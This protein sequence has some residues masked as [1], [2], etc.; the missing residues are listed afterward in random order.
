MSL[1]QRKPV[2]WFWGAIVCAL[3]LLSACSSDDDVF[4]GNS[5][6][7]GSPELANVL[8]L[9]DGRAAPTAHIM[10]VP[11][12]FNPVAGDTLP[13][14]FW[15]VTNNEGEYRFDSLPEGEFSLE[16]YHSFTKKRLLVRG[17]TASDMGSRRDTVLDTGSVTLLLP[18]MLLDE[19]VTV[20]VVGS[21]ISREVWLIDGRIVMGDLPA[22]TLDLVVEMDGE[23]PIYFD[24]VVVEPERDTKAGESLSFSFVAP[25]DLPEGVDSLAVLTDIPMVLRLDTL[26]PGY[27]SFSNLAGR[28]EATRISADGSRSKQLP[29][30]MP[31][32]DRANRGGVIWM[33]L[34]SLN[35]GDS[36][37]ITM[38]TAKD[39]MYAKD[40]F[41]TSRRYTGVFHM[42][43]VTDLS[44]ASEQSF[45]EGSAKDVI[46]ENRG[47]VGT[48]LVLTNKNA[49]VTYY[50]T[51]ASDSSKAS[52]Y[53]RKF[54]DD[55]A[56]SVWLSIDG[57]STATIFSKGDR[58]YDL[59]YD[60]D[61]GLVFSIY[62]EASTDASLDSAD[63][64]GYRL[65]FAS[66][67]VQ[68]SRNDFR[69]IAFERR[70]ENA[71][72]FIDKKK[73]SIKGVREPWDGE[74]YEGA[75]F[76][77][78]GFHGNIDELFFSGSIRGDAWNI[79]TYLNQSMNWPAL[80]PR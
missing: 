74:R 1:G 17:L 37:E 59:K 3:A 80:Q 56:F 38:N 46:L 12:D 67:E 71:T 60:P 77:I 13:D 8:V 62:H 78:G 55:I 42:D 54:E 64:A 75:N 61:S 4:A 57:D 41:P 24:S 23:A 70:G 73:I 47:A 19:Q 49:Y 18:D 51:A 25:I 58:Q 48:S 68:F 50:G 22:G 44:D 35:V 6:E 52:D 29:I 34:D 79:T 53:N 15:T 26:T 27:E 40:V 21:T 30:A 72:L 45:G 9:D 66:G 11:S 76:Q 43:P 63:A 16:A 32:F 36:I 65:Y 33:R 2:L 14:A 69:Y 10:C 5:A 7:T 39:P 28:W 31:I 20:S